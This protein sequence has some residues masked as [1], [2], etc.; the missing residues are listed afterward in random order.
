[1]K[2]P[3]CD[4]ENKDDAVKC[5]LCSADMHGQGVAAA[6]QG[7]QAQQ[8]Y[9][10]GVAPQYQGMPGGQYQPGGPEQFNNTSGMGSTA[11][12]PAEVRG[13]NWG[14]FLLSWIWS[15]GNSSWIGLLALVPYVGFIM[16]IILGIKGSEWAWQNRRWQSVEQFKATQRVWAYW[17]IGI[18]IVW[19]FIAVLAAILFPVFA[20]A[21]E[22]ARM[23]SF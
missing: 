14:A 13:W 7:Q 23:Q 16:S 19:F 5:A 1:M 21:R 15:I 2:C 18:V 12:V 3:K 11:F 17:G 20:R 22:A 4:W 10:P 6:P 9:Q 8:N